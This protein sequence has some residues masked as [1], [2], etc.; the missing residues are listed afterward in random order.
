MMRSL[1]LLEIQITTKLNE[2]ESFRLPPKTRQEIR[3]KFGLQRGAEHSSDL[4]PRDC[5]R[6]L[7]LKIV[8]RKMY[9][10]R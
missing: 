5:G 10:D 8:I 9:R 7:K 4:S 6:G 2:M 3:S 1:E